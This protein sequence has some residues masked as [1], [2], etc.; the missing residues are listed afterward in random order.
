MHEMGGLVKVPI[1]NPFWWA[2]APA[3]S[4]AN[5]P[6][7]LGSLSHLCYAQYSLEHGVKA[8]GLDYKPE[9]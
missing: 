6:P 4:T 1:G 2:F 7:R 3:V 5:T 9:K 8:F